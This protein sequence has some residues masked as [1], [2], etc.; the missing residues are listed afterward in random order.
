ML[1]EDL[2]SDAAVLL[3]QLEDWVLSNLGSRGGVVHQGLETGIGLAENGVAI[4]RNDSAGVESG[5]QV[6]VDVL[7]RV[8]FGDVVLHLEDP[9]ENFLSGESSFC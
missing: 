3:H 5:P 6:V 8:G 4:A 1:L 7:V 9:S 2:R